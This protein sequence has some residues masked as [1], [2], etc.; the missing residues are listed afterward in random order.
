V[1]KENGVLTVGYPSG[2]SLENIPNSLIEKHVIAGEL[3]EVIEPKIISSINELTEIHQSTYAQ[4][5]NMQFYKDEVGLTYAAEPADDFDALR[6]L[7]SCNDAS[8]I[9]LQ[10]STYATFKSLPLSDKVGTVKGIIT[11]N[12]EDDKNVLVVNSH[13]DINFTNTERCDL[14][15]VDCGLATEE[16]ANIIFKEDFEHLAKGVD[17]FENG[18][19]QF[20]EAGSQRFETFE[21]TGNYNVSYQESVSVRIGSYK[22]NDASTITWLI[23]PEINVSTYANATFSFVSSNSFAD[24]SNLQVLVST[25]W[26]ETA[27]GVNLATWSELTSAYVVGDADS[28]IDWFS[29]GWVDISCITVPFHIAFKYTGSGNDANDGTFELDEITIKAE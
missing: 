21:Q 6:L 5:E 26:D 27:T 4:L 23:T 14:V 1:N 28:Y 20:V 7:F 3:V 9:N 11:R 25:N 19:L 2:K 12:Y 18:W 17:V 15:E 13:N 22:S 8:S 24:E 10:T 16:S 29:S